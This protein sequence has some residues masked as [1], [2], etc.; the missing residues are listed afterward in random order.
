[1]GGGEEMLEDDIFSDDDGGRRFLGAESPPTPLSLSLNG[2][3]H[4]ICPEVSAEMTI[5][6]F[7]LF[8]GAEEEASP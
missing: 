6:L 4:S 1:M 8:L 3:P 5:S 2:V 7:L